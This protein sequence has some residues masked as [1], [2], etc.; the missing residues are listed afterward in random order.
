MNTNGHKP[1]QRNGYIAYYYPEYP[2][3]KSSGLIYEHQ[4][5]AEQDILHRPLKEG[6]TIHH[7]DGNRQN[8]KKENLIVFRSNAD[9][10]GYHQGLKLIKHQD[11]T[12]STNTASLICPLCGNKKSSE[13]SICIDCYNKKKSMNIPTKETLEIL[14][15]KYTAIEIG[16]MYH[17]SDRAVGKWLK[18]YNIKNNIA[19]KM[20]GRQPEAFKK[21]NIEQKE[22][23][24]QNQCVK[25][26]HKAF[27]VLTK[28][29][30]FLF[31]EE[32]YD[33]IS[34]KHWVK[35]GH[36]GV[37]YEYIDENGK[38]R[39]T[40]MACFLFGKGSYIHINGNLLDNRKENLRKRNK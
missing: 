5:V 20:A 10:A 40:N 24:K 11:G 31:D 32:F 36:E 38:T 30:I 18:K 19:Q 12:Y 27:G 3:S 21:K 8:N 22:M 33:V 26:G 1:F 7:I 28:G 29:E 2:S 14:I 13:S 17:V 9:H 39:C 37:V 15:Q 16:E 34:K 23:A 6:E 35:R 25:E 4:L